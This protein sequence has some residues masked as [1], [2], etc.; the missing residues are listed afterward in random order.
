MC[1]WATTL[2]FYSKTSQWRS[3]LGG[4]FDESTSDWEAKLDE[5]AEDSYETSDLEASS[6]QSPY[7]LEAMVKAT[8]EADNPR[9]VDLDAALDLLLD[10]I[11]GSKAHGMKIEGICTIHVD[12]LFMTGNTTL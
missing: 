6:D 7:S 8:R 3:N 12:D 1:L 2:F 11:T 4:E 10:P 5:S 9:S